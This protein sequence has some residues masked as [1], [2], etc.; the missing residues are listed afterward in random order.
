ML[1]RPL[2]ALLLLGAVAAPARADLPSLANEDFTLMVL[3]VMTV[4]ML[5]PM[6]AQVPVQKTVADWEKANSAAVIR[7]AVKS[8]GNS[9][10]PRRSWTRPIQASAPRWVIRRRPASTSPPS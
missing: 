8:P 3:T 5:K 6:C 2:A 7:A 9:P 10:S 4:D 1:A